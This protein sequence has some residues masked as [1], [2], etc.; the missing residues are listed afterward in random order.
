MLLPPW[1]IRPCCEDFRPQCQAKTR[2]R[3]ESRRKPL[4]PC[5]QL[6]IT[7][8]SHQQISQCRLL[9]LIRHHRLPCSGQWLVVLP[10]APY[11]NTITVQDCSATPNASDSNRKAVRDLGPR[12]G[13]RSNCLDACAYGP[14]L[15]V[16]R[17]CRRWHDQ[18]G[19]KRA[20]SLGTSH[21]LGGTSPPA[22][23]WLRDGVPMAGNHNPA[24]QPGAMCSAPILAFWAYLVFLHLTSSPLSAQPMCST[25]D[26]VI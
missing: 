11:Q 19:D 6:A 2:W 10:L 15:L 25:Y 3:R 22:T 24:V 26:R 17:V 7:A 5:L 1:P 23:T 21:A 4:E 8:S 20:E 13:S 14:Y 9:V 18:G 12:E 16:D